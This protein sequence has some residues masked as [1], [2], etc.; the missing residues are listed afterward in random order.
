[1]DATT[2]TALSGRD[3][4]TEGMEEEERGRAWHKWREIKPEVPFQ[5]NSLSLCSDL[6]LHGFI[7]LLLGML[8]VSTSSARLWGRVL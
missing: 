5:Q 2:T 8:S 4:G 7:S 1:M 6:P 3:D